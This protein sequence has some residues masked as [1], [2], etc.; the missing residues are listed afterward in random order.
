MLM[1]K[2]DK[3]WYDKVVKFQNEV[4]SDL[5]KLTKE[6]KQELDEM[7]VQYTTEIQNCYK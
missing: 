6:E 7:F 1:T 4:E 5:N 2:E 3:E